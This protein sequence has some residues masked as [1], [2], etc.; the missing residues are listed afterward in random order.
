MN[1][2]PEEVPERY[3]QASPIKLLPLGIQQVL[4]HGSLDI[5]VPI[6]I[7][8]QYKNAADRAG[9]HVKM[10]ELPSA[11]HFKL[12]DPNSEEWPVIVKETMA[13]LG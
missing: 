2:H 10:V 6:G 9:D 7:S 13:L 1:G 11:E 12:I 8:H 5:N 4:I 3:E